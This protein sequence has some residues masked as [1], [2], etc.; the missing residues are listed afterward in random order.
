MG[1]NGPLR[2][3]IVDR[4]PDAPQLRAALERGGVLVVDEDADVRLVA[5]PAATF[6]P[7]TRVLLLVNGDSLYRLDD[8]L[9]TGACGF[10][11]RTAPTRDVVD[12]IRAAAAGRALRAPLAGPVQAEVA[13]TGSMSSF[14]ATAGEPSA[15]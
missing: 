1:P 10:I 11:R 15:R 2:V 14:S 12:A 3:A 5:L 8:A 4:G 13:Q 6:D 7:T 9:R